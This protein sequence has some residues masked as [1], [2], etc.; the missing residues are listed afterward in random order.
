MKDKYLGQELLI[1]AP[2]PIRFT[3]GDKDFDQKRLMQVVHQLQEMLRR[4]RQQVGIICGNS[5][6]TGDI[7]LTA[8]AQ[9][10]AKVR[11]QIRK[12]KRG[13]E[14]IIVHRRPR[15]SSW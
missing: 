1:L 11:R 3:N 6:A 10:L 14:T 15:A 7:Q 4:L 5:L 8:F 12:V 2:T 9:E 13:H